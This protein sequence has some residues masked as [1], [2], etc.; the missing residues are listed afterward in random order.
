MNVDP[1]ADAG[2]SAC[3]WSAAEG[4]RGGGR[5]TARGVSPVVDDRE[6]AAQ[7]KQDHPEHAAGADAGVA[8][9][10]AAVV[11][12]GLGHPHDATRASVLDKLFASDVHAG[13]LGDFRFD[14][15][16][17]ITTAS[18][19]ILRVTGATPPGAGLSPDFQ[20]AILDRVVHVPS[21]LV[22]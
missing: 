15:N 6:A 11:P 21:N 22:R 8:P 20:G 12:R 13:I 19:P 2:A 14:R 9:V 10:E 1:R 17:D 4:L 5:L 18:I 16:G 7:G 3:S